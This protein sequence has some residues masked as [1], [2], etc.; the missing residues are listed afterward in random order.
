MYSNIGLT[1]R[2][3]LPLI[4]FYFGL[5]TPPLK[6]ACEKPKKVADYK[7]FFAD[8]PDSGGAKLVQQG[9]SGDPPL[10][11]NKHETIKELTTKG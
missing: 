10:T 11:G 9:A 1:C 4:R 7:L 6:D 8:D 3:T 5:T 2:E